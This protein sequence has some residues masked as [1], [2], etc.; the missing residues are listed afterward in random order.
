LKRKGR[1]A[2]TIEMYAQRIDIFLGWLRTTNLLRK[3]WEVD[4]LS[5]ATLE[6]FYD[7]LLSP[8]GRH[9]R[10]REPTTAR[11]YLETVELLWLWAYDHD[12][13]WPN[14]VPRPRRTSTEIERALPAH[15]V[16]ATW[17]DI[18]ACVT[19]LEGWHRAVGVVLYYTGLRVQ[20]AMALR[21]ADVDLERA[22]LTVRG[23]LGK[24]RAERRGRII[25]LSAH[26]VAELRGWPRDAG[27]WLVP[28]GRQ[29][30]PRHRE[31]RAR[32]ARRAWAASGVRE[33]VWDRDPW[34]CF[35]SAWQTNMLRAGAA[36]LATEYYLG[37]KLPGTGENYVDPIMAFGLVEMV[38]LIPRLE[39]PEGW[40]AAL[41]GAKGRRGYQGSRG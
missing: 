31:A 5:R 15:R 10:E 1:A 32:D 13:A 19:T 25:P 26:F 41:V 9:G 29:P 30:G 38:T 17:E 40:H 21:W 34:H 2:R 39:L 11:K 24:T 8:S 12:E 3:T 33:A 14:L 22:E 36:W 37:H 35:R 28:T 20:Q 7:H 16:A 18:T 6:A 23:Q 4:A 27:G